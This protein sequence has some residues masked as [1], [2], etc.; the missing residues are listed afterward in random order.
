MLK[1]IIEE[2]SKTSVSKSSNKEELPSW[3]EKNIEKQD[4]SP[5]E[6]QELDKLLKEF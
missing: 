5:E 1:K 6:Q 3:F 2:K 4:I